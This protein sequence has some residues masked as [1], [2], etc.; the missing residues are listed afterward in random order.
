MRRAILSR[1]VVFLAALLLGG[2]REGDSPQAL[3]REISPA[4]GGTA[5]LG[6]IS[7]VDSWNEL[8][9]QQTF[10][11]DL[12]RRIYLRLADP[13]GDSRDHPPTFEPSLAESWRLADDGRSLILRLREAT[14]SDGSPVT[15]RDVRFTWQAE[16]SPEVA[17]TGASS[18]EHILDVEALDERTV[19][20]HF[21][22]SY[23]DQLADAMDGPILPAHVFGAIPFSEWRTH[24]WSET[25]IASGPFV[26]E[27]HAP[28]EEIVLARNPRY[29]RRDRPLLD[30]LVVRIVPD[31]AALFMQLLA[32]SVDYM[33]G[34]SPKDVARARAQRGVVVIPFDEPKYDYIGWN[35]SR[36]PWD[37]PR[38][39]RALT[40]AIDREAIVESLFFGLARV[41]RGPILSFW[42]GSDRTLPPWPYDPE[43]AL[44]L[45]GS[46][47][48]AP[49]ED[50]VLERDGKPL[51]LE[52][53]TNLG[54]RVRE[55]VLVKVQEQLARIGA[56]VAPRPLEMKTFRQANAAGTYDAYVAGWRFSGKIDL[57]S[58]FGSDAI[59]PRGNNVV[60]Y[61]SARVDGLLHDLD[62]APAW[63][64]MVPI[65]HDLERAIREDAPY[66][67]LYETQ[68]IAAAGARLRGVAI[69]VPSDPL[70][71]TLSWWVAP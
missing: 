32:G 36:K 47:G 16:T 9:S 23:P 67:F 14:W 8:C 41:S 69:D 53:T 31:A 27:R 10:A 68:R 7:D 19:A 25:R 57:K 13:L 59:P 43:E 6:S 56:R 3:A 18:K 46:A 33:E 38:V 65:L 51:S 70:R 62:L 4:R 22:R 17:W 64:A 5:V 30:R 20:F 37:D 58:I 40:L 1:A 49:G 2:C 52:L 26:L 45:L 15:A 11:N 39:R 48:F 12:L 50:G 29:F 61:R 60:F 66:T 24:D 63:N 35:G 34:I 21:D 44:R 54:N 42:W 55:A 71:G 28:G